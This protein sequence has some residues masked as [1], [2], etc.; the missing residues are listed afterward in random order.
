MELSHRS[1][2]CIVPATYMTRSPQAPIFVFVLDVALFS[3]Q[4]T[5][6]PAALHSIKYLLPELAQNKLKKIGIVT[7]DTPCTAAARIRGLTPQ[8][9]AGTTASPRA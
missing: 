5:L 9:T 6:A 3:F 8:T 7:F 2:D 4:S 1:V